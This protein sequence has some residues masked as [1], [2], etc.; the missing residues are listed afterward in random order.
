MRCCLALVTLFCVGSTVLKQSFAGFPKF[1][2][3]VIDPNI[4]EVCYA[5][6]KADVNGDGMLDIV[7]VS[8]N[9]V[10]WYEAPSWTK[11]IILEEQPERDNVCIAA[12]DIDGDG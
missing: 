6:T 10:Q 1:V 7:A 8:E 9:R 12:H 11:H 3:Q 5:V 4:G 2:E